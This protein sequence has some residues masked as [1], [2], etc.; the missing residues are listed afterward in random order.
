MMN[1]YF[2]TNKTQVVDFQLLIKNIYPNPSNYF[3]RKGIKLSK[4]LYTPQYYVLH[5][6]AIRHTSYTIR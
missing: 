2:S 4:I 5:E 6:V 3:H 1:P